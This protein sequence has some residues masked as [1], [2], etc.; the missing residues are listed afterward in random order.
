M[1][2]EGTYKVHLFGLFWSKSSSWEELKIWDI[3]A[4]I[5]TSQKVQLFGLHLKKYKYLVKEGFDEM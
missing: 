4:Q 5:C 3:V 2:E 1:L